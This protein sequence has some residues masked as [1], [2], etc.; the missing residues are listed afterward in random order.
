MSIGY[1]G[2]I[3]ANMVVGAD[4]PTHGHLHQPFK[5][6]T[7][8]LRLHVHKKHVVEYGEQEE[9][10]WKVVEFHGLLDALNVY[11]DGDIDSETFSVPLDEL[12]VGID[13]LKNFDNLFDYKQ[14]AILDSLEDLE[15]SLDDAIKILERY[16][17]E[18]DTR[19][20]FIYFSFL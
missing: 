19:D 9:F 20:G 2:T 6:T 13:S 11:Y 5:L 4:T 16:V 3:F 7:M 1:N 14:K 18:A 10:N 15:V 8:G 17:E 12:Q